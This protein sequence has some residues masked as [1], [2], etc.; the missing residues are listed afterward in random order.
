MSDGT[1]LR[2]EPL[3]GVARVRFARPSAHN[4]LN[5]RLLLALDVELAALAATPT[6]RCVILTGGGDRFCPG[7]DPAVLRGDESLRVMEAGHAVLG[8]LERLPCPVI[9]AVNG[10]ALGAGCELTLACDLVY[11]HEQARFAMPQAGTGLIPAF[12]GLGR[13]AQRVGQMR[14]MELLSTG[15]RV[16]AHEACALGLCLDVFPADELMDQVLTVA[17]RIA[18]QAP[19]AVQAAKANLWAARGEGPDPSWARDRDAFARLRTTQDTAE[20]LAAAAEGR[21]P[22]WRGR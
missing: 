15:R 9:A 5:S 3:P 4:T 10:L 11:A 1:V 20:G 18:R 17:G 21:D 12:G 8:R 14:A 13:L 7:V 2:D 6:V 16:R 19:L 22:V